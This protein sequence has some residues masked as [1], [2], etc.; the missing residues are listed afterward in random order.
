M[1]ERDRKEQE[2]LKELVKDELAVLGIKLCCYLPSELQNREPTKT[3]YSRVD[4]SS[5][6]SFRKRGLAGKRDFLELCRIVESESDEDGLD[7]RWQSHLIAYL[8]F[9]LAK[10]A[11]STKSRARYLLINP[12]RLVVADVRN[13]YRISNKCRSCFL[14]ARAYK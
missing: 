2:R 9:S 7:S 4:Y 1:N 10:K 14:R 13:D 5:L 12:N 6:S 8:L 3:I 11:S